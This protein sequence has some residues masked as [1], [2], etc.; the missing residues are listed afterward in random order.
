M[1]MKVAKQGFVVITPTLCQGDTMAWAIEDEEGVFPDV[2]DTEEEAWKEIA[3]SMITELQQFVSGERE[4][5]DTSFCTDEWVASYTEYEDGEI[6]VH[7]EEGIPII[8]T[9]LE[10]WRSER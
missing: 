8:E 7:D 4:F 9:T 3:D 5:E 1:S 10:K 2:Y 6:L